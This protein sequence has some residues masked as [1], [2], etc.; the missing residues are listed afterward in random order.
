LIVDGY[1]KAEQPGIVIQLKAFLEYLTDLLPGR[2]GTP[3]D[4]HSAQGKMSPYPAR[5]QQQTP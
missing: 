3:G 1:P 5:Y 4:V 2:P